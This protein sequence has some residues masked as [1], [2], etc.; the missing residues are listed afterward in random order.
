MLLLILTEQDP[1]KAAE[2][3]I[4][5]WYSAFI[6]QS[7]AVMMQEAI[8]P[9]IQTVCAKVEQKAS[10]TMLGK[11]WEFGSRSLRLVLT[12]DQW[13]SLLSYF[14]SPA[15][16]TLERAKRNRL[17]VT[18]APHR[19]D[20]RDRRFFAQSSGW[21]AGSRRFR[22]DGILL[23]FGASR[24]RFSHLNPYITPLTLAWRFTD[25]WCRTIFR[26]LDS[27]P[28]QDCA[29][30]TDGW[31]I[32]EVQKVSTGA[33]TNDMYGKLYLYLKGLF[34]QFHGRLST[35]DVS[36]QLHNVGAENLKETLGPKS[37]D[38]IEVRLR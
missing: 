23:P 9:L 14:E 5:L 36:F 1:A 19:V 7:L 31:S 16:L 2:G 38:R 11:T 17:D 15:G 21:R 26:N 30:P 24:A 27:W 22:E 3:L 32:I 29:D 28:L 33:A 10:N 4:H 12:R 13:F 37:F 8:R 6:P 18:L 34:I 25:M 20:Y 35:L